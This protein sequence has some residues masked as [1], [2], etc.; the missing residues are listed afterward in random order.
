MIWSNFVLFGSENCFELYEM[1]LGR[2]DI[3]AFWDQVTKKIL[4][5]YLSFRNIQIKTLNRYLLF[6]DEI[7]SDEQQFF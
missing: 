7:F 4:R 3:F 6:A 5:Q 1:I 2:S